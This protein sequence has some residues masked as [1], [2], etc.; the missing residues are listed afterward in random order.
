MNSL[1]PQRPTTKWLLGI[2]AGLVVMGS[3]A[4]VERLFRSAE[5]HIRVEL[6]EA[7]TKQVSEDVRALQTG[8]NAIVVDVAE[9]KRDTD[10]MSNNIDAIAYKLQVD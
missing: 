9:L 5:D 10:H 6:L 8:V 4:L 2:I 7:Q 1:R 3:G